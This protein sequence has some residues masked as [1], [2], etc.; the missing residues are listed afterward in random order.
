M[1]PKNSFAVI[2]RWSFLAIPLLIALSCKRKGEDIST[3]TAVNPYVY[4]YTSGVISKASPIKIQFADKIAGAKEVGKPAK[5][6]LIQ[7]SPSIAGTAVWEDERTLRFDPL[8]PLPTSTAFKVEV[9][10]K[11]VIKAAKGENATFTFAFRTRDQ[12]YQSSLDGLRY[13]NEKD[14]AKPVLKGVVFTADL[15]ESPSVEGLLKASQ[16]GASLNVRWEHGADQL[17][18]YFTIEGIQRGR[19]DSE[20][21]LNWNGNS[22]GI[23][24]ATEEKVA[25]P[26]IDKFSL[27][28]ARVV[29]GQEQYILC[30]FSD[31]LQ[32]AQ[33][34]SGLISLGGYEGNLRFIIESNTVRVYPEASLTGSY[35]L[36]AAEDIRNSKNQRLNNQAVWNLR[37]E[38]V[39]PQVRLVGN[40][41]I[42]PNSNGL[43]FPFEAVGLNAVD[44]EIFKI[45]NNNIL[46]FLQDN[47]LDG[48]Y[49]LYKVGRIVL[50]EKVELQSLNPNAIAG[51]WGRYAID[52]SK[53][54]QQDDQALYS[55]RIGFRAEYANLSCLKNVPTDAEPF[56]M[57]ASE[58]EE[59]EEEVR[60]ILDYWYGPSGYS[61]DYSW[62]NRDNPCF[63]E[64]YN[65]DRYIRRNIL[66]SNLGLIAKQGA[67]QELVTVATDLRTAD[68]IGNAQIEIY[69]FQ[70]QLIGQGSTGQDGIGRIPFKGR[71]YLVV[72]KQNRE[73]GYLR[74]YDGG[75]LSMSRYDVDGAVIQKGLKGMIYGERGV[76]RPGD[77]VFLN[78]ILDDRTKRLP[79]GYPISMEIFNARGQL[80]EKRT[81]GNSVSGIYPIHFAT[82][83]DAPTGNWRVKVKAGGAVFEKVLKIETV[84]PNR[85]EIELKFPNDRLQ[86]AGEAIA[87][88]L[89]A[90][91]L[92]GAPASG[93]KALVEGQLK[94]APATFKSFPSFHFNDPARRFQEADPKTLYEGSLDGAGKA[95]VKAALLGNQQ[96][97]GMLSAIFRTRVFEPGGDFSTDNMVLPY[98]PYETYAG[99]E[100]PRNKYGDPRIDVGQSAPIRFAL[101]S[102]DGKPLANRNLSVGVYSVEWRWWWDQYYEDLSNYNTSTHYNALQRT[103]VSTNGQGVATWQFKSKRWGRYLVRVCDEESGHCAGDYIYAGYPWYGGE[104]DERFR[105]IAAM[106]SFKTDKEAYQVGETVNL[107]IPGGKSGRILVSLENGSRVI[108]TFWKESKAGENTVSFKL[109]PEMSPTV[110][111]NITLIQPHGQVENDLPIRLYGVAPI[112]VEDPATKLQPVINMPQTLKPEQT[113]TVEV[114]EKAGKA[115]AYTLAV[116]D[117]GLLGLT[118]YKT[119]DPREVFFAREA[120]GVHSWDVYDQVLGAFGGALERILSIGGDDAVDPSALNNTANRFEPVVRHLGP[121]QLAKGSANKHQIKMPNYVGAVRV[122]AVAASP[123]AYGAAEQRVP[124]RNPLMVLATAPRILTPGD[125]FQLPVNVFANETR[126]KSV[127]VTVKETSGRAAIE[128]NATQT[129]SFGGTGNKMV[130]FPVRVKNTSGVVKFQVTAQAGGESAKQEME[131]LVR[132]PNPVA[133]TVYN[134]V[135]EPGQNWAQAFKMNGTPGTR[136]GVLEVSS[137][138]PLNLGERLQFLLQYPYG[139]IEQTLSA[140]FPQLFVDRLMDLSPEDQKTTAENIKATIDRLKQFQTAEGGFAYWPGQSNPDQWA[141]SYAGHFMVEAKAKG[142]EVPAN[143]L[144]DWAKFQKKVARMWDPKMP[145]FGFGSEESHQLNQAYRLYTLAL[146]NQPDLASMNRLRELSE[147][148]QGAKWR[149]AAAYALAGKADAAKQLVGQAG[150]EVEEYNELSFT[151]GSATRDR[152]LILETLVLI[153]DKRR[154][155]ELANYLSQQLNSKSWFSTQTVAQSLV[156]MARY[157]GENKPADGFSFSYQLSGA[158]AVTAGSKNP[159]MQID[160]AAAKIQDG[161]LQIRNTGKN[162]VFVRLILGGQPAPGEEAAVSNDLDISVAFKNLDGTSLNPGN[163]P[164]GRDFIAEVKVA[165]PGS[166]PIPYQELALSQVFPSG[167]E[168][169][170]TRMG[171]MSGS[172]QSGFDYQDFRDDRVNTFFDLTENQTKVYR[173]QVNAAYQGRFYMPAV[174]CSAMYDNS[175][176]AASKGQWVVVNAPRGI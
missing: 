6:D 112:N 97:P 143:L 138:P 31:P 48:D 118:R 129:V 90:S 20:V 148:K 74:L 134:E 43:M 85:I 18:H 101:A 68:P 1:I 130:Y 62:E 98:S 111:A 52:L 23:K 39:K 57:T 125:Q 135:V 64:Y 127:Q 141:S 46:Q 56:G 161:N 42:M 17:A 81:T 149:L 171:E 41:V 124:V 35:T 79:D 145:A 87:G 166:R 77:S 26:S 73:R 2:L 160:L 16:P 120:L 172:T 8:E 34:L 66:A 107:N 121:F 136:S 173:V 159:M 153:K 92:H 131:I 45:F 128:G 22:L 4:G 139:C 99:V 146:A 132:N 174:G 50:Q 157:V 72:A 115:M 14:Y 117:E 104:Q 55:V 175:I 19:K 65:S 59:S 44:V 169:I 75:A 91:W 82:N 49:D 119:P 152:A 116:V 7:F 96:A 165:H 83:A 51:K 103:T 88:N 78:F 28:D 60:S 21:R 164:Q 5:K 70:Q 170:N 156:A 11:K 113:F 13:P 69:D 126:I 154:A 163:L 142:Y 9:D 53:M 67:N 102:P 110:Y 150:T 63:S 80:Q 176:S 155:A 32:P 95:T 137:V 162:K 109:T 71:P 122:M 158:K 54:I 94:S 123:G 36:T 37:F 29:Q 3:L 89:Q 47:P 25:I 93:L 10:V 12:Y 38:D 114:K 15:A 40:G 24:S 151:Y 84:K 30:E 61:E 147:L 144:T 140:G 106:L 100:I 27:L 76:W 168:I 105:D 58:I 108:E 33:L 133:Y 167:W 86:G